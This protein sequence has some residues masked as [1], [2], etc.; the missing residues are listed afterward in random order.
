MSGLTVFLVI[1]WALGGAGI[2]N[3]L[4]PLHDKSVHAY[5]FAFLWPLWFAVGIIV[6]ILSGIKALV[7]VE[8]KR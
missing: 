6:I 4:T 5:V 1:A 8:G 2:L 7:S 3:I